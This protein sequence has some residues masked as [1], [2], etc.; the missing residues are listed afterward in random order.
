MGVHLWDTE[1]SVDMITR[2]WMT[3]AL[4]AALAAAG[5]CGEPEDAPPGRSSQTRPGRPAPRAA[6]GGSVWTVERVAVVEKM[7]VPECVVVDPDTGAAYVS[8]IEA[9][10]G[11][12]WSDDGKGFIARLKPGGELDALRW[13]DSGP[14][15]PLNAPKGMCLMKGSL[16]VADNTRVTRFVLA[17]PAAAGTVRGIAGRRLNDMATDGRAAYVSDTAAGKVY[18]IREDGPR[19][20]PAPEGVN[21][22]TFFDG[23]MFAVSWS[24]HEVYELDPS[25]KAAPAPFGVAGHFKALDGIEVLDDGTFV[26]SDNPGN[27]V[28]T[29]GPDR[30]TVRTLCEPNTPA[31][32]GLDRR[33]GLLYVPSF[34]G[35]RVIVYK[36]TRK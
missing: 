18:E 35:N 7:L 6:E 27:R 19:E 17:V 32:I 11:G 10:E 14:R 3:L 36:L 30:R 13:R 5:G 26:V 22:I 34:E 4:A 31:D 21:G 24:G 23:K 25:G 16:Y 20:V 2:M 1:G 15:A 9:A 28:C 8:N 33:R 29:I 12:Y